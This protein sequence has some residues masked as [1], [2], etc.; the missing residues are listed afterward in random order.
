MDRV[1][2]R[3]PYPLVIHRAKAIQEFFGKEVCTVYIG[4]G[5]VTLIIIVLILFLIFRR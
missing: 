3:S 1:S 2:E 4:G 5:L